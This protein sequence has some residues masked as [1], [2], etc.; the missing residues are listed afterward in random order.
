[1]SRALLLNANWAPLNFIPDYRAVRLIMLD[2]AEYVYDFQT[3]EKCVWGEPFT[4]PGPTLDAP[5]KTF[6]VPATLRLK[7]FVNKRWKAPRFRKRVLFNRDNWR[8]QY[9]GVKLGYHNVEVE[10]IM[11]QSRG[12]DTSWRNCVTSCHDCNKKKDNKTPE[13]AGMSLLSRPSDPK[14][15]HFWDASRQ[16]LWHSSWE[17]FIPKD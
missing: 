9:C 1:M 15:L 4:S 2:R 7:K 17:N 14:K 6:D 11:P 5:L 16:E 12:G 10:H 8:C 3:G 13:E